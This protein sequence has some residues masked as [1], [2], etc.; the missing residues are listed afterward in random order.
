M[1]RFAVLP[2]SISQKTS[3]CPLSKIDEIYLQYIH[4]ICDIYHE[5]NFFTRETNNNRFGQCLGSTEDELE[6]PKKTV[7]ISVLR[8]TKHKSC[9][10]VNSEVVVSPW[11][12]NSQ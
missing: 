10:A 1:N 8:P 9:V 11:G 2:F 7:R 3:L 12:R 6:F 5:D 4:R